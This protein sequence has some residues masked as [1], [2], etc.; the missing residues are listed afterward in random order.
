MLARWLQF[1]ASIM[2]RNKNSVAS[3]CPAS[4]FRPSLSEI[5]HVAVGVLAVSVFAGC[6]VA[7]SGEQPPYVAD[8]GDDP[9]P[10]T[11]QTYRIDGL[12]LPFST[13]QADRM[14]FSLDGDE[15][16][17]PDNAAG[18]LYS[19]LNGQSDTARQ[20]L[21]DSVQRRLDNGDV[22][23]V[24]QVA[25]C[26]DNNGP[27]GYAQVSVR[28]ASDLDGDGVLEL[29]DGPAVPATGF[30]LNGTVQ[31]RNGSA[32][33]PMASLVDVFGTEAPGWGEVHAVAVEFR[34]T[35]GGNAEGRIG[36]G[37]PEEQLQ[38]LAPPLAAFFTTWL[39]RG[40]ST[41]AA[42][43]DTNNDGQVSAEEFRAT[44][45]YRAM[46]SPDVDLYSDYDGEAVL[47]PG[48]DGVKDHLSF[49]ASYTATLV[50]VE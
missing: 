41:F 15:R 31:V 49:G 10:L 38:L 33:A 42:E 7:S 4:G 25:T 29:S 36:F 5:G 16:G 27:D 6:L 37:V 9:C 11:T 40:V 45:V 46:F 12:E 3:T 50:D 30:L 23:W 17:R 35:G 28:R 21:S 20:D 48:R 1:I 44:K 34:A 2:T 8:S 32:Q 24:V 43:A 19:M 39:E 26:A 13:S 22:L 18:S 47:W 14:G